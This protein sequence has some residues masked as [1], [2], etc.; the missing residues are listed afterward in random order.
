MNHYESIPIGKENAISKH[1]LCRLWQKDERQVRRIVEQLRKHDNGDDY[2]IVSTAHRAG[3]Y[4]TD[5]RSQIKA[6]KNEVTRRGKHTFRPLRKVNRILGVDEQQISF[7]NNLKIARMEAR[8]KGDEV[9]RELRK[10]DKR[11][12]K[13]LLS[14]IENG[15]C[16]PTP[17]QLQIMSK[18][19]QKTIEELT[20]LS[21]V[22]SI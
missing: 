20:G 9:I 10:L 13:S 2:V 18:L 14:K 1:E 11:F 17:E 5:N 4:R 16:M 15:L 21:I 6:F 22:E 8:L 12:D 19:Y 3:Y 7:T